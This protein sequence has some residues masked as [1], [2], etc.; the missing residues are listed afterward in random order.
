[1]NDAAPLFPHG[2]ENGRRV[3]YITY[4]GDCRLVDRGADRPPALV[5]TRTLQ[6]ALSCVYPG[7]ILQLLPG[8]YWPPILFDEET[9]NPPACKPI[10]LADLRGRSRAPITIRGLGARTIL[11]GGLGGVPRDSMLPDMRHFAFFKAQG[12]AWLEF[13]NLHVASCWPCFLYLQD[14]SYV[15]VRRVTCADSRYMVYARGGGC[16]HILLEDNHWTQDQTGSI[17]N[18]LLWLD[19][20]RKR[21]FYYNGGIFGSLGIPGSVVIRRNTVRDA[22]NAMRM[23]AEKGCGDSQNH[24]VEFYEN[25]LERI[26]DN[27][28]EPERSAVNWWVRHNRIRD[29]HAWFSLD[30]VE[31]GFWYFF[32]NRGVALNAPGTALDPNRGGKVYKYDKKGPMPAKPV[33]AFHNSLLLRASLFKG[34]NTTRLG[35]YANAVLFA[36]RGEDERPAE[37]DRFA[38]RDFLRKAWPR[39][40]RLDGDLTNVPFPARLAALGQERHGAADPQARFE[41]PDAWDLR[42][43]RGGRPGVPVHLR[44]RRDWPGR[45]AWRSPDNALAGAYDAQG[46][47]LEGPAFVFLRPRKPLEG[48]AERPRLVRLRRDGL[49]LRLYFSTRLA[50]GEATLRLGA[51]EARAQAVARVEDRALTLEL[52][53]EFAGRELTE[54]LLPVGFQ[55][56]DGQ[57]VTAWAS[58]FAGLGV[59]GDDEDEPG[60][61]TPVAFCDCGREEL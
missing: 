39:E 55:G 42:L 36:A 35:H 6:D 26:R 30:E 10:K 23:K 54:V 28:V 22:F 31:G 41:N 50:P 58:V 48:Y 4:K 1:M 13:E 8:K 9:G 40:V 59:Y 43:A 33:F 45:R 60:P 47:L 38:G 11:D 7:D 37:D 29:A 14:S 16:H 56:A 20:K 5:Q 34:G 21:Y 61:P 25:T 27:V 51:G 12:C 15:S 57:R 19:S 3:L 18:D 17:W 32:G 44:P 24:N 49:A 52:P 46:N 53:A 2:E